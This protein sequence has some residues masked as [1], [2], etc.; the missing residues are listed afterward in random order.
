MLRQAL[1]DQ[2]AEARLLV[3]LAEAHAGLRRF[4]EALRE[5][6]SAAAVLRR[7]GDAR[8]EREVEALAARLPCGTSAGRASARFRSSVVSTEFVTQC[9]FQGPTSLRTCQWARPIW[10]LWKA[11]TPTR[12]H[13]T[14]TQSRIDLCTGLSVVPFMCVAAGFPR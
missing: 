1:G 10:S 5:Y 6:R 9:G 13:Y 2:P 3:R 8:G 4:E 12:L 11:D 14:R 7:T